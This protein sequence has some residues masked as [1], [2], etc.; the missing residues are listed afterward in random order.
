VRRTAPRPIAIAVEAFAERLAPQTPLARI[1]AAWES[2][3]GPAAAAQ[4]RPIAERGGVVTIACRE[5][6]WAQELELLG[7]AIVA[8]LNS[9]LG[10]KTVAQLRCKVG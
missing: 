6:V 8:R 1:Q 3:A 5:A 9:E 2:A 10:S 7:P 4:A